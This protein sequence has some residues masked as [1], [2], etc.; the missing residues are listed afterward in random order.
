[1]LLAVV[2][3]ISVTSGWADCQSECQDDFQ[4]EAASCKENYSD[5][6]DADELQTCLDNAKSSY[7]A[8]LNECEE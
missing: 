7:E 3:F 6:D 1:M 5:P 2:I 4:S 8:C